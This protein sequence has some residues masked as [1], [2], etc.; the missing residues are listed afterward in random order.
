MA[1]IEK[2]SDMTNH[3]KTTEMPHSARILVDTSAWRKVLVIPNRIDL[4]LGLHKITWSLETKDNARIVACE[5]NPKRDGDPE[6]EIQNS[7]QSATLC[8]E[9]RDSDDDVD[10]SYVVRV[11]VGNKEYSSEPADTHWKD[12]LKVSLDQD[13]QTVSTTM[14]LTSMSSG[15]VIRNHP[16]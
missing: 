10:L 9:N 1:A 13:Q 16:I 4:S 5:F 2:E 3:N 15:P 12:A 8:I 11:R 14:F 7:G 6:P